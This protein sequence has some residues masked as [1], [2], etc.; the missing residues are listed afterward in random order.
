MELILL[1]TGAPPPR[2]D[3]NGP[4]NGI[5][6]NEK[7][8]LVDA[9]R[10]VS[11]QIV[12]AG[13]RPAEVDQL[14]FTH[15]HSD[16]YSGFGDFYV[17]RWLGG[18]ER[19]LQVWGPAPVESMV[20]KMLDYYEYDV[21]LRIDEGVPRAGSTVEVKVLSPGDSFEVD[22][23]GIRVDKGTRHGNVDD[24]L[25]YR[26]DADGRSVVIAS[27][28]SP[29]DRLAPLAKG[30]SLL[31]MHFCVPHIFEK[32]GITRS[33]TPSVI[34]H[35]A[36]AEEVARAAKEAGAD[37]LAFSHIVPPVTSNQE[38]LEALSDFYEGEVIAGE[39]LMRIQV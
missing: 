30:T 39:D 11:Q 12:K 25:S 17:S 24:I 34:G 31:L 35:H 33:F 26:F 16:H 4:A 36:S 28:G 10:N 7:L 2:P 20:Q 14:F 3:K 19:P 15:F 37:R 18:G 22:G 6:V 23:I 32:Y 5:V 38:A 9:A 13:F 21:E 8:Y 29:T 27:D 1:G